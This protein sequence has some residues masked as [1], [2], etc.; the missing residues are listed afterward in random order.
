MNASSCLLHN[1]VQ[2]T[3]LCHL[4]Y[5]VLQRLPAWDVQTNSQQLIVF[6]YWIHHLTHRWETIH[7]C[8]IVDLN[9]TAMM[10]FEQ[11]PI[12]CF[13]V[14]KI[15]RDLVGENKLTDAWAFQFPLANAW[16]YA[17]AELPD[18]PVVSKRFWAS[19]PTLHQP[20][21]ACCIRKSPGGC[22][23]DTVNLSET[24][25]LVLHKPLQ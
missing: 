11:C 17:E 14:N 15:G 8:A 16:L 19:I 5:L 4:Y 12:G 2:Q 18:A 1:I 9:N 7:N 13:S 21:F 23:T 25:I 24:F 22:D 6:I 20:S 3:F 10:C